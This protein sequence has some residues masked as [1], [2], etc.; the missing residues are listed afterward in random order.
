MLELRILNASLQLTHHVFGTN[1]LHVI[2]TDDECSTNVLCSANEHG[3][4]TTHDDI[5]AMCTAD[6]N[7]VLQQQCRNRASKLLDTDDELRYL[8]QRSN[9]LQQRIDKLWRRLPND[10]LQYYLRQ[11]LSFALPTVKLLPS[12]LLPHKLLPTA[13]HQ[14][15]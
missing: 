1:D 12:K 6:A 5:D 15:Q 13:I 11:Q 2:P 9:A 14:L 8:L 4:L 3:L 7:D 10:D